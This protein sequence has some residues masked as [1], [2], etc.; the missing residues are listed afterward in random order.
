MR[1][2]ARFLAASAVA[3]LV[4]LSGCGDD[5]STTEAETGSSPTSPPAQTDSPSATPTPTRSADHGDDDHDGKTD[6]HVETDDH[7]VEI[8][9]EIEHGRTRP[10]GQRVQV[11]PGQTIRLEVDSDI[12]DELHLHSDPEKSFE[13][14]VGEDQRFEF[15]LDAPGVYELESHETDQ[16][17]VSI[18]VQS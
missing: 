14:R 10:A 11:Q 4:L 8:E 12:A 17:I 9:I 15:S 13:V 18:Q 6:D 5:D 3:T 16:Q 2:P 7:A 1:K